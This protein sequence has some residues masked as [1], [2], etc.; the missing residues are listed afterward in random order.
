MEVKNTFLNG[1]LDEE[2]YMDLPLGFDG[3]YE[4][5][6]RSCIILQALSKWE[7]GDSNSLHTANQSSCN[8][9]RGIEAEY[10]ALA[11]GTCELIWLQRML[12]EFKIPSK[13]PMKVFCDNKVAI[14]I[15]YNP[16]HHDR[17]KHVDAT[18]NHH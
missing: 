6:D 10:R 1:E 12:E 16:V 5:L 14:S 8:T 11:Q 18:H 13:K 3:G 17:T 9:L 4:G 2:A 15:A 7:S